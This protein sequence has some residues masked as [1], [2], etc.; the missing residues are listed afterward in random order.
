RRRAFADRRR[1]AG[2]LSA[3]A[4]RSPGRSDGRAAVRMSR[5]RLRPRFAG[6]GKWTAEVFPP[7]ITLEADRARA[8]H[9]LVL[10]EGVDLHRPR[11]PRPFDAGGE[12]I[13][14]AFAH[15]HQLRARSADALDLR[16]SRNARQVD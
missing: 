14:V 4:T 6:Q 13:G 12:R 10:I 7:L 9:R 3:G 1:S 15:Q 16:W 2:L 11:L 8:H 5:D